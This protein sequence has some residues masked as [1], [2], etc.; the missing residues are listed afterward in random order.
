MADIVCKVERGGITVTSALGQRFQANTLHF[1]RNGV[2]ELARRPGL[3]GDDFIQKIAP[4]GGAKRPPARQQLVKHHT[5]TE[6]IGTP[7][8]PV[9][10]PARLLGAHVGRGAGITRA[11]AHLG[12]A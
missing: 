10:F 5:Q 4:V 1:T 6:N 2:V 7:I 11:G 9:P 8:H 12:V 3:H